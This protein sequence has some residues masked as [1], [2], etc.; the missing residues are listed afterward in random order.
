MT[1]APS[2]G[3]THTSGRSPQRSSGRAITAASCTSGWAITS[4]SSVTDEIH[5]PPDFTTSFARSLI[6]M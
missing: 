1:S 3:T 6:T 2:S 5:S 4:F